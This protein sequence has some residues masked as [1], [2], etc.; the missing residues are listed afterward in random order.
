MPAWIV[1]GYWL[2]ATRRLPAFTLYCM[3]WDI[4]FYQENSGSLGCDSILVQL[5]TELL[6]DDDMAQVQKK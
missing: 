4:V 1:A 5:Y 3:S 2:A 6:L